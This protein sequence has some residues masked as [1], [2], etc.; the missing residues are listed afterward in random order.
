[1]VKLKFSEHGAT[2]FDK[3]YARGRQLLFWHFGDK[4][5]LSLKEL[6]NI[7][8]PE[9]ESY[10]GTSDILIN[11]II[12]SEN[13]NR[14]YA[15][16]F[17]PAHSWM[18]GRWTKIW[19]LMK[20][21]K[22]EEPIQVL[23]YGGIYF[24][25]DG[26]HRVSTGRLLGREYIHAR[27]TKLTVPY[28]LPETFSRSDLLHFHKLVDFQKKTGF[29]TAVPQARF[30]VRRLKTWALLE[31][32]IRQWS[33]A[34][35][36]RH[37]ES[38]GHA[39]Q[40]DKQDLIW[41]NTT[42]ALIINYVRSN[43][44]HYLFPGWG[45]TDVVIEMLRFWNT[46]SKPDELWIGEMYALFIKHSRHRR[47]FLV[48]IQLFSERIKSFFRTAC[49][50]R[51]RFLRLSN[52][53][54]YRPEFKLPADTKKK[55]WHILYRELFGDHALKMKKKLGRPPYLPELVCDWYD[56]IWLPRTE[57]QQEKV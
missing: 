12:G 4:T 48:P 41:Y 52:L 36:K 49:D 27:V 3:A 43:S 32:E 24:V 45:D 57:M 14:D 18:G 42:Y 47:F 30:D 8:P 15:E 31:K 9:G 28:M 46:L 2:H 44:L 50:E 7:A 1:M 29:L 33:P 26:H 5:L 54:Q 17:F 10:A 22:L 35:F 19:D 16:G 23:E 13:R 34:W 25:R 55:Y 20:K 40:Q 37:P 11:K 21:N 51:C 39:E 38:H 56:N 53:K 6:T